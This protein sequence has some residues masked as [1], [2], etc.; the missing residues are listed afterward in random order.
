MP[1]WKR[2]RAGDHYTNRQSHYHFVTETFKILRDPRE[3]FKCIV[4]S[5]ERFRTIRHPFR[6]SEAT[7]TAGNSP[8][9]PAKSSHR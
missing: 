6:I 9:I 7:S 3:H 8:E 5:H 1:G 2:V 4:T